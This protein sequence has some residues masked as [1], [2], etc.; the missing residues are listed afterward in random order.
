MRRF[1]SIGL[2]LLLFACQ[3]CCQQTTSGLR[4]A[5]KLNRG[6]IVSVNADNTAFLSW[7][8]LLNDK[9]NQAFDVYK[10]MEGEN[11][12]NK[13]NNKLQKVDVLIV[14]KISVN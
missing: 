12:F 7:R 9:A 13:L 14:G 1:L 2:C 5:E 8:L 4:E 10:R 6:L 3:G 11:N